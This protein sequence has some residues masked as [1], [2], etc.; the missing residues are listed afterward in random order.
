MGMPA[1][2][3]GERVGV[4]GSEWPPVACVRAFRSHSP[5]HRQQRFRDAHGSV[6]G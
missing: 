2:A 3:V 1:H 5:T 4:I 6:I